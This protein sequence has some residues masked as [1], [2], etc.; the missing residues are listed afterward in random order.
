MEKIKK[1]HPATQHQLANDRSSDSQNGC[2][3][4]K[5]GRV[6]AVTIAFSQTCV[7]NF[8]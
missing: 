6:I 5:G 2:V 3:S 1:P 8:F 7:G 4:R